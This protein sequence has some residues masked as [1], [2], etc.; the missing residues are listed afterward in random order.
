MTASITRGSGNT[1]TITITDTTT[2]RTFTI[3]QA[4][5][6]PGSSA[7]WIEEAPT[8]G[9]HIATLAHYGQTTFDSGT[10]NNASPSLVTSDG[11]VM[12]QHRTQVSTPSLP[13]SDGDGSNIAYGSTSPSPPSS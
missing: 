4:Y 6:G 5:S 9:G 7:E 1:W 11:G 3:A 2:G 12:I 8:I 13:D 10:V